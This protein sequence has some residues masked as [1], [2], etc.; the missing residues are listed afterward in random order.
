MQHL[1][2]SGENH[3]GKTAGDIMY[4]DKAC[5]DHL[6][7]SLRMRIGDELT[8]SDGIGGNFTARITAVSDGRVELLLTGEDIVQRELPADLH[9]FQG[10]PKG[11]KMDRIIRQATE[12][13]AVSVTPLLMNRCVVKLKA[14]RTAKKFARWQQIADEAAHQSKR[15]RRLVVHEPI[16][17]GTLCERAGIYDRLL[18]PYEASAGMACGEPAETASDL[19]EKRIRSVGIVIGPE[20]GITSTEVAMLT[21]AGARICSLGSRIL[22]TETAGPALLARLMLSLEE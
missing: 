19:S 16:T 8:V 7:R 9:L 11:D 15:Q 10:V 6:L 22:R 4:P 1:L 21:A 2:L 12:L 5:S 20:G 13:G 17:V 18:L 14:E 3:T